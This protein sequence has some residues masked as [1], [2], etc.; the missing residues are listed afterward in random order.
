MNEK[1]FMYWVLAAALPIIAFGSYLDTVLIGDG[2]FTTYFFVSAW[3][4]AILGLG[5][6]IGFKYGRVEVGRNARGK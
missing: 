2:T 4:Y 1:Q 5:L 3:E 6:Y